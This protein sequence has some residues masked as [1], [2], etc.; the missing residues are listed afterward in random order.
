M[1]NRAGPGVGA[2]GAHYLPET[3]HPSELSLILSRLC[4]L[5]CGVHPLL[6]NMHRSLKK[7]LHP[8]MN[9]NAYL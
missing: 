6:S 2:G 8:P 4:D 5:F 3:L 1:N 9:K 7:I